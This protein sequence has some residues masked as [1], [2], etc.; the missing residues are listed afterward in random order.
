[1]G[2]YNF[3]NIATNPCTIPQ[4]WEM[5]LLGIMSRQW[6]FSLSNI[7]QGSHQYIQ[8]AHFSPNIMPSMMPHESYGSWLWLQTCKTVIFVAE[9]DEKFLSDQ[10]MNLNN[11]SKAWYK[12]KTVCFVLWE[13]WDDYFFH[14]P[15]LVEGESTYT[16]STMVG[17]EFFH[18]ITHHPGQ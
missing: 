2:I 15:V 7:S 18:E 6:C 13:N 1:M 16:K 5:T 17:N 11:E 8:S 4:T 3:F 9:L 14:P 12:I 10:R